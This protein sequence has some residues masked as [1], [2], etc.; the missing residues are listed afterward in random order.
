MLNA[1][2]SSRLHPLSMFLFSIHPLDSTYNVILSIK[3]DLNCF[4]FC[5]AVRDRNGHLDSQYFLVITI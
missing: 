3:N 5:L 2:C 1:G 4:P